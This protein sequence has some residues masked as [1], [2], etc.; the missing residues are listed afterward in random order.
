MIKF[1]TMKV[2]PKNQS[3]QKWTSKNDSRVT[4]I[5]KLLRKTSLDELP[6]FL[7]VLKG[8]MSLVGPR[9]ERPHFVNSFRKEIPNY[10]I[11]HKFKAG[12]TGWAQINGLRGDTDIKKRIEYDL[13]YIQNW[14]IT[15]DMKILIKTL[16][17]GFVS[18]NAY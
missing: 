1:R 13:H 8:E 15:F 5:G 6:Q 9:P 2:A 7:N 11:R 10:M 14:S 3:D 16:Y 12:I 4:S 17:K 18:P